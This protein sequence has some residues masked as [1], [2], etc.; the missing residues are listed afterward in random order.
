M[1]RY[2]TG[3][4]HRPY[5][6]FGRPAEITNRRNKMGILSAYEKGGKTSHGESCNCSMS[7][8]RDGPKI[9][10]KVIHEFRGSRSET[11]DEFPHLQYCTDSSHS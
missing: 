4:F 1:L 10:V 6:E 2:S 11:D 7:S 9:V 5:S 3:K 8:I